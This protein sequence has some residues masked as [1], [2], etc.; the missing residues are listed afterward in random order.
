[1]NT[2]VLVFVLNEDDGEKGERDIEAMMTE[3]SY[4]YLFS[5]KLSTSPKIVAVT[6]P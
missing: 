6:L 4:K 5:Y 1:M 2:R 3:I